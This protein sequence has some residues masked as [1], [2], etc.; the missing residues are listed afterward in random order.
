[1]DGSVKGTIHKVV[2]AVDLAGAGESHQFDFTGIS[3]FESRSGTGRE[4]EAESPGGSAVEVQSGV[5]FI[6]MK[7]ASNLYRPVTLIGNDQR[8][9]FEAG[10]GNEIRSSRRMNDFSRDHAGHSR[11]GLWTVTSLVPS[12]KVASA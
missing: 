9:D 5:Y 1:M 12:R 4:V 6:K 11:T 3:R 7:M 10:I 8:P 2:E